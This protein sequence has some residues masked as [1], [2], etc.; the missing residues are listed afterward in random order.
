M[1]SVSAF[2]CQRPHVF[3][4]EF[5][6]RLR[7]QI[8]LPFPVLGKYYSRSMEHLSPL[9]RSKAIEI[10]NALLEVGPEEGMAIRSAIAKAT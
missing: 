3:L 4:P 2:R 9:V 6:P 10:A 1:T 8:R 7:A 5:F